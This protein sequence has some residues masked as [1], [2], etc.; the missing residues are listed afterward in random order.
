MAK[1]RRKI[2]NYSQNSGNCLSFCTIQSYKGL[3]NSIIILTDIE[4]Y[5]DNKLLY[6]G[7]SRA[8]AALYIFESDAAHAERIKLLLKAA[9]ND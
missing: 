4:S 3:E 2:L 1:S 7:L 5:A 8:R 6:V 9:G